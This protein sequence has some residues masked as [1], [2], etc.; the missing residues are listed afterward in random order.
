M[1]RDISSGGDQIRDVMVL[2]LQTVLNIDKEVTLPNVLHLPLP[3]EG[4]IDR[5]AHLL[6]DSKAQ[7]AS[8]TTDHQVAQCGEKHQHLGTL[9]RHKIVF[10]V[11]KT[12]QAMSVPT[13][14]STGEPHVVDVTYNTPP[15][16]TRSVGA[17]LPTETNSRW[18]AIYRTIRQI[19]SHLMRY[20]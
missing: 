1:G 4:V 2:P 10:V 11:V 13:I 14:R 6:V 16:A 8:G 5:E 7:V 19:L 3:E 9:H 15:R 12:I 20:P 17:G 18:V